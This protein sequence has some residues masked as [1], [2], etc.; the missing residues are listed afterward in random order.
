MEKNLLLKEQQVLKALNKKTF[1]YDNFQ[2]KIILIKNIDESFNLQF[3]LDEEKPKTLLPHLEQNMDICYVAPDARNIRNISDFEECKSKIQKII[4][5]WKKIDIDEIVYEASSYLNNRNN[6][7]KVFLSIDNDLNEGKHGFEIQDFKVNEKKWKII[8]TWKKGKTSQNIEI[9]KMT[10]QEFIDLGY[11]NNKKFREIIKQKEKCAKNKKK[12]TIL[13]I[14]GN[15]TYHFIYFNAD[16]RYLTIDNCKTSYKYSR[17]PL[18]SNIN[19]KNIMIIGV[20]AI[21]SH[22]SELIGSLWPNKIFIW[23]GDY[24]L[25]GSS[26]RQNYSSC[27][28]PYFK[29]SFLKERLS[30]YKGV[31]VETF[32]LKF[33]ENNKINIIDV[34]FDYIIDC[35][36]EGVIAKEFNEISKYAKDSTIIAA[37]Y[38]QNNLI[39]KICNFQTLKNEGVRNKWHKYDIEQAKNNG[40]KRTFKGCS[41]VL[42]YSYIDVYHISAIFVS[43]L[44]NYKGDGYAFKENKS[45]RS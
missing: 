14:N 24:N 33:Q 8:K 12:G 16:D 37:S 25:A 1:T 27:D 17:T 18:K 29:V 19:N 39:T 28:T 32:L 40:M 30:K 43:E 2:I 5:T 42:E 36:G 10:G 26:T 31:N 6:E 44:L 20:G 11:V 21:G 7:K 22:V 41:G 45:F 3:K 38:I 4:A 23:D 35:T 34:K 9:V 15:K 13:K